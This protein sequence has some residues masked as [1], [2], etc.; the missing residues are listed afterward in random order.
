[1][2]PGKKGI[3]HTGKSYGITGL[4][5][6]A[7]WRNTKMAGLLSEMMKKKRYRENNC[8]ERDGKGVIRF[9]F[10]CMVAFLMLDI[11]S[12]YGLLF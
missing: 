12:F 5:R 1:M 6:V 9:F 8:R 11:F 7:L 10:F 4:G 3:I 2:S